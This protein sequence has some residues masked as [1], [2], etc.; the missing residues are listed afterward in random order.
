MD[1]I[2]LKDVLIA[3]LAFVGGVVGWQA[4][5]RI[6]TRTAES[7]D[8]AVERQAESTI[9]QDLID[10]VQDE[11]TELRSHF[12]KQLT[13]MK[14]EIGVLRVTLSEEQEYIQELREHI[15]LQKPPPPP[16]FKPRVQLPETI[17]IEAE[18]VEL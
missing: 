3:L 11:I 9:T 10:G 18:I 1:A 15:Y 7:S 8:L 4:Q 2:A 16:S 14:V 6:A 13:E 12:R 5:K 17:K